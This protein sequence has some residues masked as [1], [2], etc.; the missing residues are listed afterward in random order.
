MGVGRR[1]AFGVRQLAAALFL[2]ANNVLGTISALRRRQRVCPHIGIR[3]VPP[4]T[5]ATADSN[6]GQF[7]GHAA[8]RGQ[9][10]NY[11]PVT[12]SDSVPKG[13]PWRSPYWQPGKRRSTN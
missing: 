5:S 3:M 11:E 13:V 9:D 12:L 10:P 6:K 4:H 7:A 8:L 2:C 1:E